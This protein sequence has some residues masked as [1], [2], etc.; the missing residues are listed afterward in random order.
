[1]I[2]KEA[3]REQYE[4]E[5]GKKHGNALFSTTDYASWLEKR[6]VKNCSTPVFVKSLPTDDELD[7]AAV[8]YCKSVYSDRP[9]IDDYQ[10]GVEAFDAGAVWMKERL[11]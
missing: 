8:E 3:L 6:I 5:T 11:T 4:T 10:D 1:M 2:T 7:E 9:E